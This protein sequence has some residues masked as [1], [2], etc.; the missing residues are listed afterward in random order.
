MHHLL[1][2]TG[3]T[4]DVFGPEFE[5]NRLR[6]RTLQDYV[7]VYGDRGPKFDP[8]SRWEYSNYGFIL[9]GILIEKVSGES[10]YDYVRKNIYLP[11]GMTQR[12]RN[13]RMN[14]LLIAAS[15]TPKWAATVNGG[16]MLTLHRDSD[17]RQK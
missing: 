13:R 10:Y 1:K 7:K 4:G 2:H 6:L 17:C 8:G 12:G 9:L 5:K 15:D 11:A 14:S 3:G 16:Q